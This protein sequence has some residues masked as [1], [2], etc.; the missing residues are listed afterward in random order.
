MYQERQVLEQAL[1][2]CM[3]S[4]TC[5]MIIPASSSGSPP[6]Y[7]RRADVFERLCLKMF[8]ILALLRYQMMLPRS[9]IPL[10][11]RRSGGM[12]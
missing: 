2:V 5:A 4:C 8:L 7:R 10:E 11:A 1:R 6:E 9:S 12:L 3:S